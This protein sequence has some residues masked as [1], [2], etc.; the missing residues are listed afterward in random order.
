MSDMFFNITSRYPLDFLE[1]IK[2]VLRA[3]YLINIK[4]FY[5]YSKLLDLIR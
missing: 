4:F 5:N 3:F 1:Y 2:T